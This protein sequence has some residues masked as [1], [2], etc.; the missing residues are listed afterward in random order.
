M[1][2]SIVL[3]QQAALEKFPYLHYIYNAIIEAYGQKGSCRTVGF[4][5][6][7]FQKIEAEL[8]ETALLLIE[9]PEGSSIKKRLWEKINLP[10]L[11]KHLQ[12]ENI[13]LIGA[14]LP[15]LKVVKGTRRWNFVPDI[16]Q[17]IPPRSGKPA[18]NAQIKKQQR[19]LDELLHADIIVSYSP[20][21]IE[22]LQTKLPDANSK[23]IAWLPL[24]ERKYLDG[25]L[26]TDEIQERFKEQN[27]NESA[28][29]LLDARGAVDAE[30]I[31]YLKAFSYFKKWQ[32]SS[33]QLG[34]L[35]P[36]SLHKNSDFME[37]YNSYFYKEDVHLLSEL[38]TKSLY[39]W[40]K[41]A[42][43]VVV[44]NDNDQGLDI[45][46]AA[47]S[48]GTLIIAPD[49]PAGSLLLPKARFDLAEIEVE[50]LGRVLISSYKS[51]ILRSRHI[52]AGLEYAMN[53]ADDKPPV[54]F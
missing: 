16:Q 49:S 3:F 9:L 51:E 39:A 31:T 5:E 21:A 6:A 7:S 34:L 15:L 24:P 25:A 33:M 29:F 41:N 32:R 12:P 30:L 50:P 19:R 36:A 1:K 2:T 38:D 47:A 37:K 44:P 27:T 46:L 18:K 45:Q 42:Y 8:K 35:L 23:M 11:V 48:L 40:I 14:N 54:I 52:Q 20:T 28:F 13:F 10:A 26:Y 17:V 22:Q 53:W 43:A 4:Q